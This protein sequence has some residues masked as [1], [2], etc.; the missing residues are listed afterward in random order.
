ML[1]GHKTGLSCVDARE[2]FVV[3]AED[4]PVVTAEEKAVDFAEDKAVVYAE[5]KPVACPRDPNGVDETAAARLCGQWNWDLLAGHRFVFCIHN[6]FVFCKLNSFLFCRDNRFVFCKH[7]KARV[8]VVSGLR[9][10]RILKNGPPINNK[11]GR[12]WSVA[13]GGSG[14]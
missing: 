9:R 13:S 12:L 11:L 7:N 1:C 4:K 10:V 14:F 2:A 6:S 8:A 5:D 3:F